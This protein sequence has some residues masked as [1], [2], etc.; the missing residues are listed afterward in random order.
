MKVVLELLGNSGS[1]KKVTIRHDIVIGRGSECN[2]K[3]VAPLIS[4]RHCTLRFK[5]TSASVTDLGSSNG[6]YLNGHKLEPNQ[7]YKLKEGMELS[8]GGVKFLVK[9]RLDAD[10]AKAIL[11]AR[12]KAKAAPE[13]PVPG[14]SP[15][16]TKT[17]SSGSK[18]SSSRKAA[19]TQAE[20]SPESAKAKARAAAKLKA[21]Q[22][23]KAKT[24]AEGKA[25]KP[26]AKPSGKQSAADRKPA[27]EKPADSKATDSSRIRTEDD[28]ALD[29]L[30]DD[31]K[32]SAGKQSPTKDK[33]VAKE[34][35]KGK[36]DE[37]RITVD[38]DEQLFSDSPSTGAAG[39]AVAGAAAASE[40]ADAA[41]E[42][43]AKPRKKSIPV[44]DPGDDDWEFD[45]PSLDALDS[46]P[47]VFGATAESPSQA[48]EPL[49]DLSE[50]AAEESP[51]EISSAIS[52]DQ[53]SPATESDGNDAI[54][55]NTAIGEEA[56]EDLVADSDFES[57]EFD[58]DSAAAENDAVEYAVVAPESDEPFD[59]E[60][61]WDLGQGKVDPAAETLQAADF[62]AIEPEA[63]S[64]PESPSEV[65]KAFD[66]PSTGE[67]EVLDSVADQTSDVAQEAEP[68]ADVQQQ[69]ETFENIVAEEVEEVIKEVTPETVAEAE[70]SEDAED[71]AWAF[72][73]DD[74]DEVAEPVAV[75]EEDD[76][77]DHIV[78]EEVEDV[79]EEVELEPLPEIEE[80]VAEEVD[81]FEG[82]DDE[83]VAIVDEVNE[84]ATSA[85]DEFNWDGVDD[86]G[87]LVSDVPLPSA[88]PKMTRPG[89][90]N[91]ARIAAAGIPDAMD[92]LEE[93][94]EEADAEEI[95]VAE[96]Q[97]VDEEVELFEATD[98]E[99]I[100]DEDDALNWLS[101][102]E[103]APMEVVDAFE[104]QT[105]D[106]VDALDDNASDDDDA[107]SW[108]SDEDE[109]E[110]DTGST[111]STSVASES[112]DDDALNWLNDDDNDSDGDDDELQKFLSG[113]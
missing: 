56:A 14:K 5:E 38:D 72:L 39:I 31:V 60:A 84:T 87:S 54:S 57:Q 92:F 13:T 37:N 98:A 4:R 20:I 67:P 107:M 52:E 97:E 113:F 102:D 103:E 10:E 24:A 66:E 45:L 71:S 18:A 51:S 19:A 110:H 26:T 82:L 25:E 8:I 61:E 95:A 68:I 75:I 89:N 7:K 76:A 93:D 2:L 65:G 59:G 79:I 16:T 108:L 27:S 104:E 63:F 69:D 11:K 58:E 77:V 50:P 86:F 35:A 47:D 112:D 40:L 29:F 55:E 46:R 105:A 44:P 83:P 94:E 101:D 90:A 70:V 80:V 73:N 81:E 96:V 99:A 53:I 12:K 6:T 74:D 100:S 64:I 17:P 28:D 22:E 9:V 85:G 78:A 34:T 41:A 42:T 88:K 36:S 23:L 106:A 43:V 15:K 1:V 109:E 3:L 33:P 30:N 48:D 62:A 21:E 32:T 91:P 111:P 49:A